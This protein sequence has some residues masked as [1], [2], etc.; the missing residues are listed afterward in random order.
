[1]SVSRIPPDEVTEEWRDRH[2]PPISRRR[3]P[4]V[5]ALQE[6]TAA[7]AITEGRVEAGIVVVEVL[8]SSGVPSL[9]RRRWA[10]R[11]GVTALDPSSVFVVALRGKV[12]RL[13]S[14]NLDAA[15]ASPAD[16]P[17]S[18][19]RCC[20][21]PRDDHALL[22][23]VRTGLTGIRW[24]VRGGETGGI[25]NGSLSFSGRSWSAARPFLQRVDDSPPSRPPRRDGIT[26][27]TAA[28]GGFADI[29]EGSR[30][31]ERAG[32]AA[33]SDRSRSGQADAPQRAGPVR[34]PSN[35]RADVLA[36]F[37]R[38]APGDVVPFPV[39]TVI[40]GMSLNRM[41]PHPPPP[42]RAAFPARG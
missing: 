23:H 37:P 31:V 24:V 40:W 17:F 27:G 32:T 13:G 8:R 3:H 12:A 14:T 25:R 22:P 33:P 34:P 28:G 35:L 1:M 38:H 20:D 29:R 5:A 11:P 42:S 19:G 30:R 6:A 21:A 4:S 36:P 9:P 10:V 16:L 2:V 15:P 41:A 18:E 26:H 7:P 39:S